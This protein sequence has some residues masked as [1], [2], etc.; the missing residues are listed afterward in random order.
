MAPSHAVGKEQ[1]DPGK[2]P[3]A[4]N[5]RLPRP[6]SAEVTTAGLLA[7]RSRCLQLR[8]SHGIGQMSPHLFPI[9]PR[10]EPSKRPYRGKNLLARE[11]LTSRRPELLT[12]V[13]CVSLFGGAWI[14]HEIA[15][16]RERRQSKKEASQAPGEPV[17][18]VDVVGRRAIAADPASF[19]SL[20]SGAERT[21]SR[22]ERHNAHR[23]RTQGDLR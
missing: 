2:A 10:W 21:A 15:I 8:G 18:G 13:R 19:H 6:R 4:T 9:D 16:W 5:H 7:R 14:L 20:S 3:K 11:T 22:S 1:H 17:S 23:G 12:Q